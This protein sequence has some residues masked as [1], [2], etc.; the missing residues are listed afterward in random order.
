MI[1]AR[2]ENGE[3][4]PLNEDDRRELER[5]FPDGNVQLNSDNCPELAAEIERQ[6]AL[7][8]AQNKTAYEALARYD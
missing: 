4:I 2:I 6:S 8:L 5:F 7:L 1:H 3:V